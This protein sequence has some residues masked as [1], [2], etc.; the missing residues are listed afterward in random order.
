M[1]YTIIIFY[2]VMVVLHLY[3]S[4]LINYDKAPDD[5]KFDSNITESVEYY[6]NIPN[7]DLSEDIY[8]YKFPIM[9]FYFLH[10]I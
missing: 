4:N 7:V 5:I 3:Y 1:E 6:N 8:N 10:G 9:I 2:C